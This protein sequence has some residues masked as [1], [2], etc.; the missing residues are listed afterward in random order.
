MQVICGMCQ[1]TCPLSSSSSASHFRWPP[2][3][4][5]LGAPPRLAPRNAWRSRGHVEPTLITSRAEVEEA[6]VNR[7]CAGICRGEKG[8][9]SVRVCRSVLSE[10]QPVPPS[11]VQDKR[12]KTSRS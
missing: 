2:S 10:D 7:L 1:W 6:N 4:S 11:E 9:L 8:K 12:S 5:F 3:P